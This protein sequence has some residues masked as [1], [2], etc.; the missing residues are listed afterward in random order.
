MSKMT[1]GLLG[2]LLTASIMAT[3]LAPYPGELRGKIIQITKDGVLI[4][5]AFKTGETDATSRPIFVTGT[6]FLKGFKGNVV[7]GDAIDVK[8]LSDGIYTYT[9]VLGA[10]ATVKAFRF[11]D[12]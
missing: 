1:Y 2:C 4:D 7:D 12:Q 10:S 11:V 8:A 5:G 6:L 9:T 3:D